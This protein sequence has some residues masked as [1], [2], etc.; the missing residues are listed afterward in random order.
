MTVGAQACDGDGA[1]DA[2]HRRK[3]A[4]QEHRVAVGVSVGAGGRRRDLHAGRDAADRDRDFGRVGRP[5][6]ELADLDLAG[7]GARCVVASD[8]VGRHITQSHRVRPRGQAGEYD[9][10]IRAHG[11]LAVV[12]RDDVAVEVGIPAGRDHRYPQGASGGRRRVVP[13]GC[14]RER[15]G[16]AEPQRCRWNTHGCTSHPHARPARS[17]STQLARPPG[18]VIPPLLRAASTVRRFS[19]RTRR[20]TA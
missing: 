2:D 1:V 15:Q 7:V 18:Q 10:I 20:P 4:V 16:E 8:A 13:T 19:A 17:I 6:R 3:R 14:G 9:G 11:L 5:H 12:H